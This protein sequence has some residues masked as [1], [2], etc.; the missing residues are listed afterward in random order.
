[1]PDAGLERTRRRDER[2]PQ[3]ADPLEVLAA[4]GFT[5]TK[6]EQGETFPELVRDDGF[7][8]LVPSGKI[9]LYKTASICRNY[10][11]GYF[12]EDTYE[13]SL[14]GRFAR[15]HK[16]ESIEKQYGAE[17]AAI[18]ESDKLRLHYV[19]FPVEL[20]FDLFVQELDRMHIHTPQAEYTRT[21]YQHLQKIIP[22]NE[23]LYAQL[24]REERI[25][26]SQQIDEIARDFL[27]M[28]TTPEWEENREVPAQA[29]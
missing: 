25:H 12:I 21:L 7:Q 11:E 26:V 4:E 23:V 2:V 18:R 20:R 16:W 24:T 22:R 19:M 15:K 27:R 14:E 5:V 28:L 29:A 1:M 10:L 3:Q 6:G 13:D 8:S 17:I 9:A